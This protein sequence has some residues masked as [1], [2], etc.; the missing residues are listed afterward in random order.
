ME[1]SQKNVSLR[2]AVGG[3]AISL[4]GRRLYLEKGDP[5]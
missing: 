1:F 3:E 5:E 2:T 4:S